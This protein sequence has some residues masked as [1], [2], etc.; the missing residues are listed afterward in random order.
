MPTIMATQNRSWCD[1]NQQTSPSFVA[2]AFRRRWSLGRLFLDSDPANQGIVIRLDRV[3]STS[4]WMSECKRGASAGA[5]SSNLQAAHG[6]DLDLQT[7]LRVSR[8]RIVG[9][10]TIIVTTGKC[11]FSGDMRLACKK[12]PFRHPKQGPCPLFA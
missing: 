3:S 10:Q 2:G 7:L 9:C 5:C 4:A 6:R 11:G 12:F 1:S 8:S